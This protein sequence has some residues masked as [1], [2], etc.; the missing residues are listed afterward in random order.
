[1]KKHRLVFIE[2]SDVL[3][4]LVRRVTRLAEKRLKDGKRTVH[5]IDA[6]GLPMKWAGYEIP[7]PLASLDVRGLKMCQGALAESVEKQEVQDLVS[8]LLNDTK[9]SVDVKFSVALID[10]CYKSKEP[11]ILFFWER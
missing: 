6:T 5:C 7:L 10:R 4:T 8:R 2:G 11:G 3:D 1:M 9:K